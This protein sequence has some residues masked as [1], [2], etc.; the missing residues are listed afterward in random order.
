MMT[1]L[2]YRKAINAN[3]LQ[4]KAYRI[5]AAHFQYTLHPSHNSRYP[6]DKVRLEAKIMSNPVKHLSKSYWDLK[7]KVGLRFSAPTQVSVLN[8]CTGLTSLLTSMLLPIIK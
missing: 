4:S 7:V 5:S 3:L 1:R 2:S 8:Y 6:S